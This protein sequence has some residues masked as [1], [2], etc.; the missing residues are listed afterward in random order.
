M[1]VYFPLGGG[2]I[3]QADCLTSADQVIP[4]WLVSASISGTFETEQSCNYPWF[5]DAGLN[6]N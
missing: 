4:D 3:Y 6:I 2:K 5:G 1:Q